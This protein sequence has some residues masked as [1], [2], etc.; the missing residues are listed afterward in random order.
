[1][2]PALIL[3]GGLLHQGGGG[4]IVGTGS[5]NTGVYCALFCYF[6]IY[7]RLFFK[8]EVE[9]NI[10]SWESSSQNFVCKLCLPPLF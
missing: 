6:E 5:A 1:M 9:K 7:G 4:M 8:T 3:K 10:G 2:E